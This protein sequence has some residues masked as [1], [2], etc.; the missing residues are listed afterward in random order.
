MNDISERIKAQL[1]WIDFYNKTG[2]SVLDLLHDDL[3]NTINK[4]KNNTPKPWY[5]KWIK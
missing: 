1:E 3:Q 5:L 4:V 2:K